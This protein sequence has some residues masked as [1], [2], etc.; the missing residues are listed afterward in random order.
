MNKKGLGKNSPDRFAAFHRRRQS[1]FCVAFCLA[2]SI[3]HSACTELEKPKTEPF[4]AATA[5]PAK[6]EFRW[7]NGKTPKSFD[8]A[9]AVAAPETDVVRALFEGLT[10]TDS[11]T[12]KEM[13][14][15]AEKWTSSEDFKTW[16]FYLREDAKWSNGKPVTAGD[17][18][19]SWK[20]LAE[21]GETAANNDLLNNIV[22]LPLKTAALPL[23][24]T[25]P[26]DLLLDSVS[27]RN[28][29]LLP[30][31][32]GLS[33]QQATGKPLGDIATAGTKTEEPAA[34]VK[35][36]FG[37]VAESERV[38]KVSL[39]RPDKDFPK[40]VAN[41]IFRPIYDDGKNLEGKLDVGIIT[42][43]AFGI[44]SIGKDGITLHRS[45][46]YWNREAVKLERVRFVPMENAEKA[47]E[48]YRAGELDAVTNAEFAPL[49]LKLLTPYEDFRKARHAALNFYEINIEKAPF[50]DRRVREALAISI[51]RERL[52]EGELEGSTQPAFTF[53]PFGQTVKVRITQDKEKAREL[54][55]EAGFPEGENF[56]VIRLLVNRN[57]TQQ[58]VARSVARMWKQN[59]NLETEIIVKEPAELDAARTSGDFDLVR[60]GVV[61]PTADEAA[62]IIALFGHAQKVDE[63]PTDLINADRIRTDSRQKVRQVNSNSSG[64]VLPGD[65]K[66]SSDGNP[67]IILTEE[68]AVYE[69]RAIPLYFPT[70]Y[71]L[72]RPYVY[73]F[74]MNSLDALS[75]A[76]VM[77][78]NDWQPKKANGES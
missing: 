2:V 63:Q 43:G 66:S 35:N 27:K 61:F 13:P 69:L 64:D 19:R 17:F 8:P 72:V 4:Y 78:D 42:N 18:V 36:K 25:E 70:S 10:E 1:L 54:L 9:K 59:L 38:L 21:L 62:N 68:A 24:T 75:L 45:T 65:A 48:A 30:D 28:S 31:Q 16:T 44:S 3:F 56:P 76:D 41:S 33:D 58:R 6:Q 15:V 14:G 71:S 11:K 67:G 7:S 26:A 39:I 40:L 12:L 22:G 20:R 53:L 47:L 46:S 50:G 60:R 73:G 55:D 23:A 51:E 52:T 57:D 32:S 29:P 34:I 74:E 37:F 77:I 5:P 49:A